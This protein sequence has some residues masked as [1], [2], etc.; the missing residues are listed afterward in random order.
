MAKG[1]RDALYKEYIM[2]DF[3]ETFGFMS[4]LAIYAEK[5]DHH[6]E[7][8]N[9]YNKLQITLSTHTA[10]GISQYDVNFASFADALLQKKKN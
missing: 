1:D 8:F 9:V 4:S 2:K 10:N 3:I 5:H 7:W 6:P